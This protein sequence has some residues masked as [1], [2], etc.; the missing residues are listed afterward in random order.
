[1]NNDD[2]YIFLKFD[3]IDEQNIFIATNKQ[4]IIDMFISCFTPNKDY[5]VIRNNNDDVQ[6]FEDILT[7]NA[8]HRFFFITVDDVVD[9]SSRNI[10]AMCIIRD[11]DDVVESDIKIKSYTVFDIVE[12]KDKY[13]Y[14]RDKKI[15]PVLEAL[16]KNND[17]AGV[18]ALLLNNIHTYLKTIGKKKL[19]LVPESMRSKEARDGYLHSNSNNCKLLDN[20]YASNM[21][22]IKYYEKVGYSI[23]KYVYYFD[24]CEDNRTKY[25][26]YNVMYIDL[27]KIH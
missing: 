1:M 27:L 23:L 13:T 3:N 22:L 24:R 19:Y 21:T 2:N 6:F 10:A 7:Y 12:K 11:S 26:L 25:L 16:C 15:G 20:Y 17:Y 4:K 8:K 18:G 9:D 5:D 14:I